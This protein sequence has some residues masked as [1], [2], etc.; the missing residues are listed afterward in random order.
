MKTKIVQYLIIFSFFSCAAIK[1]P[2]G[3][4]KDVKGPILISVTPVNNSINIDPK[5][6]ITLTFDELLDPSSI[7]NS[8]ETKAQYK[9]QV[10]GN[11]IIIRPNKQWEKNSL[12][13]EIKELKQLL[14]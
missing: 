11:R 14:K 4:P 6:I 5:Q 1:S 9:A 2:G 12:I 13:E 7:H 8:I 3:G 10:K